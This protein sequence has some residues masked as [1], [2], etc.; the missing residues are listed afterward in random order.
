MKSTNSSYASIQPSLPRLNR[1]S[2]LYLP[3][4]LVEAKRD[5][6]RRT[7]IAPVHH[8]IRNYFQQRPTGRRR[9][10]GQFLARSCGQLLCLRASVIETIAFDQDG[11]EGFP[12]VGPRRSQHAASAVGEN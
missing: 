10:A 4:A 12:Q 6:D 3:G 7:S 11:A 8:A 2:S 5:T 9:Q 1:T